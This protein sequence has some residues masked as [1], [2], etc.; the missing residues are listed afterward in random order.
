M[1]VSVA[2]AYNP[3]YPRGRDQEDHSLKPARAGQIVCKT[4]SQKKKKKPI[5]KKGWW[6][7]SIVPE[8]KPKYCKKQPQRN[9][10]WW[11]I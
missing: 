11:P 6:S 1:W 7:G 5:T 2:H 10:Q 3:S 8:F 4:L 9:D